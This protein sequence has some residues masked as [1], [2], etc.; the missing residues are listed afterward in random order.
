M[1][2]RREVFSLTEL[3][4]DCMQSLGSTA[5]RR[6]IKWDVVQW[7]RGVADDKLVRY[8]SSCEFAKASVPELKVYADI[9]LVERVIENLLVNALRFT[10]NGGS[11]AVFLSQQAHRCRIA[12]VDNG[13]GI[14]AADLPHVFDR[15]FSHRSQGGKN[16]DHAGLGLTIVQRIIQLHGQSVSVVSA[17][18][19]GTAVVFTLATAEPS[20]LNNDR[21]ERAAPGPAIATRRRVP[22]TT[23][24]A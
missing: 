2:L 10:D 18:G 5:S 11:I 20:R 7:P 23:E 22:E 8:L 21:D 9:A 19:M 15:H 12:I 1:T 6:S 14:D 16:K 17:K 24:G 13:H 3:V 4:S